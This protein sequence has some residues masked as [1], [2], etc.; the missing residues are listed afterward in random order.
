[1]RKIRSRQWFHLAVC[2][3]LLA[4][5]AP[6]QGDP[7]LGEAAAAVTAVGDALPGTDA[8]GFAEAKA[9]FMT[10]E[11][12]T[13][14]L[15]PIFNERACGNCHTPGS[16]GG[17]GTQIERRF[18]TTFFDF[19][20][21]EHF[22]PLAN[23][24]NGPF[25]ARGGSLRQLQTVGSFT[26]LNGQACTVPLE[27]EPPEATIHN[28]GRLTTP[29]FGLGLVDAMPDSFFDNLA[30]AQ[31]SSIRGIANRVKI[32]L[33]NPTDPSQSLGGT[34]V[35]R[36]GWKA[37]VAT[38]TQFAADAYV[39]E[40]GITT[41][42]CIKGTSVLDFATESQPNGIAQPAGCDDLAPPQPAGNGIPAGTD[43][44][45]GSCAGGLTEIQDDVAEFAEFMTRLA[46]PPRGAI[47]AAVTAGQTVFQNAGCAGCHVLTTFTTPATP[48]NGVPG[49]F[50][51]QPF[52]DFLVHD[53]GSLGD[54]IGNWGDLIAV[55]RRM[56][57]APLWGLRFRTLFLHDGRTSDLATAITQHAGQGAAAAIA[58]NILSATNKSNLIA[59]LQSL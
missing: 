30:S 38:L 15:G 27:H 7:E 3:G 28:V 13:D 5:C 23:D 4:G 37:G 10:V 59:F 46:P 34:R 42:H 18:G 49:N 56:R 41:Q 1:M 11:G 58:F 19:F 55:T 25:P 9:A 47:T 16:I 53:M 57:T 52:S 29:L 21:V 32:L 48:G 17:A 39:N 8:T 26:G 40:M 12:L 2:G 24:G 45:V 54:R 20:F 35:G 51:F 6:G 31:P 22:D 43:D 36:F 44:A 14:G 50:S 33:P